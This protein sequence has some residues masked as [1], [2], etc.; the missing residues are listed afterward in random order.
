MYSIVTTLIASI[1]LGYG[2]YAVLAQGWSRTGASFFAVCLA[3]ACWQGSLAFLPQ[4]SAPATLMA[5]VKFGYVMTLFLPSCLYHFLTEISERAGD[6]KLVLLSYL[7]SSLLTVGAVATDR[8]VPGYYRYSW[9]YYAMAGPLHPLHAIQAVSVLARGIYVCWLR[10]RNTAPKRRMMLRLC[11]AG[12][13]LF[14]FAALDDMC[15]YGIDIYPPGAV[16][17]VLSLGA[18]S[19]A[20]M[21][22]NLLNPMA[23]AAT[24]AHEMRTPL[25]SIRNQA[26]G[27]NVHFSTL[28]S[29]YLLAVEHGL[30]EASIRPLTLSRLSAMGEMIEHEVDRTNTAL[31]MMLAN[32]KMD[33]IDRAAFAC[34]SVSR[35]VAEAMERYPFEEHERQRVAVGVLADFQF[36]GS[37]NLLILVVFN[38][39]K[40]ALYATAAAG[41]G[42][43]TIT[44]AVTE[45]ENQLVVVDTGTGVASDALP[46]IFEPFF[47]TK[48]GTGAGI[49]LAFCERVMR[50]FEG[51]IHCASVAGVSTTLTLTFP[52][53]S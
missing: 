15:K 49:G 25:R 46:R 13:F 41:R 20:V 32:I 24:V 8:F 50:A 27:M 34:Y 14:S 21:K 10:Q 42:S 2:I 9:G 40:N 28:M 4:L 33:R 29:G 37:D 48:R 6:R 53:L 5:V 17:V 18:I 39:L 26:N 3:A 16:F 45:N 11:M 31:D 52:R 1:F 36:F 44:S 7:V 35:C 47:T 51:S 19:L 23:I 38:L 12:A 30:C 22:Y 43:V